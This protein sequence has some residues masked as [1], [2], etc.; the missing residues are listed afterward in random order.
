MLAKTSQSPSRSSS[1]SKPLSVAAFSRRDAHW[2]AADFAASP[3]VVRCGSALTRMFVGFGATQCES[4]RVVAQNGV[5]G[6]GYHDG[7]K[8]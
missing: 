7:G 2:P 6:P 5:S 8:N 1:W 3:N 4:L